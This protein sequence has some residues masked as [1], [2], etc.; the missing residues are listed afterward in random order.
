MP[1]SSQVLRLLVAGITCLLGAC[2]MSPQQLAYRERLELGFVTPE[3]VERFKTPE[4]EQLSLVAEARG[5]VAHHSRALDQQLMQAA[6]T[7]DIAR[8]AALLAEGAQVNATDAS[9]G[10]ALMIAVREGEVDS[11]RVL[12]KAGAYAD[13]RGGAMPPLAA[14]ALRG[15]T[16]LARLLIR[17]GANVEAVGANELSALMNAVKLNHLGMAKVLIDAGAN[18]RVVDRAGDNLLAVAV[19]EG[20]SEMLALLLKL[21][22]P[23]DLADRNGL[24]ALYWADHLKRPDLS[25]LLLNAGADPARKKTEI[26]VSQSYQLGEF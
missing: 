10:T 24:T 17:N 15:H 22:V 12:L 13:G 5:R 4:H 25:R 2:A 16:V 14:A 3:D 20:N 11:A 19:T 1:S 21:G 18:T 9:G 7:S 23:V 6:G 8:I 26:R